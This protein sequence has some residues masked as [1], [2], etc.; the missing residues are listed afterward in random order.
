MQ[1][2]TSAATIEKLREIIARYGLPV[3][4]MNVNGPNFFLLSL[5]IS[6]QR[7]ALNTLKFHHM[8]QL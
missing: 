3:N 1:S 8:I 4:I 5:R 7:M 6:W 2:T